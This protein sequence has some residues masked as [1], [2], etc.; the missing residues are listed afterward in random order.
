MIPRHTEPTDADLFDD[1]RAEMAIAPS[2]SF[3]ARVR[4]RVAGDA[5]GGRPSWP[6]VAG[7]AAAG[8]VGLVIAL[9]PRGGDNVR[10]P[11]AAHT[12]VAAPAVAPAPTVEAARAVEASRAVVAPAPAATIDAPAAPSVSP[13]AFDP[14]RDVIIAPDDRLGVA[15]LVAELERAAAVGDDRIVRELARVLSIDHDDEVRVMALHEPAAIDIAPIGVRRIGDASE[16]IP[17]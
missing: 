1:L 8:M 11:E 9:V 17:R 16:G 4:Q 7:L 6:W 13:P 5:I 10:E 14:F 2:S 15:P 12:V 3:E